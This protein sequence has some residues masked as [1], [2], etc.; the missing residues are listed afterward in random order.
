MS[1]AAAPRRPSGGAPRA[2]RRSPLGVAVVAVAVVIAALLL[3][4]QFWTEVMWFGQL[5]FSRVIW[6]EWGMRAALFAGGFAIMAGAVFWSFTAA[7][8]SRPVYAPSTPEQATLDQYR[9]AVE[10]LRRVVMIAAPVLVG[11]FA[12]VAASAQWRTVLLAFNS[13]PF[14]ENDPQFGMDLG[15]FVFMLPALR[16][17]VGFLISVVVIAGIA[18]VITHYLYGGLRVG[19]AAAGGPRT[20]PAARIHLAVIGAALLLLIAANYWLDRYSILTNAGDRFDGASYSDVHAVIPAKGILAVVAIFVA[21]LFIVTA[22]RGDWRLPA[23]GVGLMVVS[24]IAIGGIYPAVVQRF[25]VNPNAQELESEYIQRNIDATL[26]AFGIDDV[27]KEPY[28]ATTQAEEG[29]LRA[30]ADTAASIRLLD[31]QI[32]SPSFRQLQQNKQYYNFNDSLSVDKYEIDGESRDTVIAVRELNL[33]GLGQD[34]R[35]WV[36]DHT[37]YTHG[38]GVVAAYGNQPGPDGRPA[39]FEGGIPSQG[40]ITDLEGEYEPRIYFSPS[41][42][43]YS[44]VGAPEG[45]EAWELDYQA[46]D[47]DDG[48]Q[49]N[50]TFTGDAG[51]DVGT[52]GSKL[53]YALKFGEEQLLF[54]DR[55]TSESQILYDRDPQQRVSKVAPW[56]TLDNRVYPAVVD[57]RVKWIVDAYTTSDAVPYSTSTPLDEAVADTL[58]QQAGAPVE[59]PEE[60]NYIRNSVK[61]TV[62]AYDGSVDLYAWDDQDP[63]L[64]AWT[65][66]FPTSVKPMSEISGDLMSHLRYPEDLFKVQ[67]TLLSQYHVTDSA[68][69]FSGQDFWNNPTDPTSEATTAPLQPPYYLTL[70][71]PGQEESTFSLTSTFIPGGNTD[72]EVL[73][74]FLAVD[75]D[76]GNEAGKKGED[77]GKLRLLELPRDT[78]VP[79]P[80]QVQNNFDSNPTISEQLNILQIGASTVRRGNQLTLPVGGGLLYVQPVYIQSTGGTQFPLLR[81]V[82]V[83]FGDDIGFADTLDEALDQVFGGDSGAQAGD[84]GAAAEDEAPTAPPTGEGETGTEPTQ[85]PTEEPSG[86]S[87]PE[88][89]EQP[90]SELDAALQDARQALEDSNTAQRAGDWAAYGEAQDRLQKA[91]E[92]AIAAEEAQQQG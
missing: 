31:P 53:L 3:L 89:T 50:T 55:V 91:L 80:G 43:T 23:I 81:K 12:G 87:T 84:A 10:P 49:V 44:I 39:F 4:A 57:G 69:F 45:T 65:N 33:D 54:S 28:D 88:S 83:A 64:K 17:T 1:F 72:R 16:F 29:A 70:Q 56:L 34:Q 92:E 85:E 76:A 86:E 36:N 25:Q 63:I 78:T 19:P 59:L 58:T 42:T 75:A 40:A 27:E 71:M 24:A 62:D 35:N 90:S 14:G 8:R 13:E 6:T 38:Y 74:G 82:L 66:V 9:E 2:R 18:G 30:D 73:T 79:G 20:T 48:G 41:T 47:A 32:V 11:F 51:P 52:F 37:V 21:A 15:F 26:S 61:A 7:Y 60:V 68:E 5:G 22:F 77:Y 67:R 46:D